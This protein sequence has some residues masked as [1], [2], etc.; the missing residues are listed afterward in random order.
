MAAGKV[1]HGGAVKG[2]VYGGKLRTPAPPAA[3]S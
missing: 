3:E 2:K 1:V